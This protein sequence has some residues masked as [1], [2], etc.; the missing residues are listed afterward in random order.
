MTSA[1]KQLQ[2]ALK[3]VMPLLDANMHSVKQRQMNDFPTK[4]VID[5]T[6]RYWIASDIVGADEKSLDTVAVFSAAAKTFIDLR[7]ALESVSSE[8]RPGY[9]AKVD[10]LRAVFTDYGY[11]ETHKSL[12]IPMDPTSWLATQADPDHGY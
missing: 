9:Q 1:L 12:K 7:S 5:C 8:T 10:R 3:E 6:H 11:T 2:V 4:E